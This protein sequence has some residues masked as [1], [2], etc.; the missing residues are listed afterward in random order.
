MIPVFQYTYVLNRGSDVNELVPIEPDAPGALAVGSTADVVAAWLSGR[1]PRTLRAYRFDLDDFARFVQAPSPAAAVEALLTGGHGLANRMA[2]AYLANLKARDL[3]PATIARR[4]AA[5]RSLVKVARLIGR[6]TWSIDVESPKVTPY[7]NTAGPS[8]GVWK[9]IHD[10][11]RRRAGVPRLEVEGKRNLA[12]LLLLHDRVLRRG[13]AV[14]LDLADVDLTAEP[15]G[16]IDI[17]GKGKA[18]SESITLNKRTRDA[19]KD[20]I[21]VRGPDPGPLFIRLDRAAGDQPG[22]LSGD[23]VNRMV[24]RSSWWVGQERETR[25]H[26]L[27]HAGITRALDKTGGNVRTVKKFSRHAKIDTLLRYD[28]NRSDVAGDITRMFDDDD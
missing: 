8:Q 9:D 27:R 20:W 16:S 14:A 24:R 12:L 11:A 25:A 13:E 17:V 18:E 15:Y 4:L 5:L 23:A 26:G 1:N 19:L 3:A 22:R 21:G 28:D 10:D 6:V 2:L 7:R